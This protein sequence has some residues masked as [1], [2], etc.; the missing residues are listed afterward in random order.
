MILTSQRRNPLK[1][2]HPSIRKQRK[3]QHMRIVDLFLLMYLISKLI[4][5]NPTQYTLRLNLSDFCDIEDLCSYFL[6][7]SFISWSD[8][9]G[10]PVT[11]RGNYSPL[12]N[13]DNFKFWYQPMCIFCIFVLLYFSLY[14]FIWQSEVLCDHPLQKERLFPVF[15][16]PN[17]R[18]MRF[19][20][21]CTQFN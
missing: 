14:F 3:K 21:S 16:L 8:K 18:L 11:P 20:V 17:T 19:N 4:L 7:V 2:A 13:Q 9:A 10:C 12:L 6:Y 1:G 5:I 15:D